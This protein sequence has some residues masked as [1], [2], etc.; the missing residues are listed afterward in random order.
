[1]AGIGFE[2]KRLFHKKG[3]LKVVDYINNELKYENDFNHPSFY[4]VP[5]VQLG[6]K[7]NII[8]DYYNSICNSLSNHTN[9]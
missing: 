2:L 3:V 8:K 6:L 7:F 5:F 1:M 9:Y 4:E